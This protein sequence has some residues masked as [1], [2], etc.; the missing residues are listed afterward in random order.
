[1]PGAAGVAVAP[2]GSVHTTLPG[3]APQGPGEGASSQQWGE[4]LLTLL[5]VLKKAN[6]PNLFLCHCGTFQ[7]IM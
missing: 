1:M 3:P 7:H 2:L 5:S 6:S 4:N